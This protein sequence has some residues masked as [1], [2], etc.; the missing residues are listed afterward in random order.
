MTPTNPDNDFTPFLPTTYNI[1]EESDRMPSY[2]VDNLSNFAD[3]INDKVIGAYTEDVASQNGKKFSYDTT[4]KVR[5]GA[6]AIARI[7]SFVPQT[8]PLPIDDVNEQFVI[9]L[10]YG[11]ASLPCSKVGAGDGDYFSFFSEGNVKIQFT[12]S[13]TKLVITT[14]GTTAAYSGF[15]IIEFIRDGT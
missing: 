1:P 11:S 3:V 4:K 7:K 8:I 2:L 14:N 15:I 9:S 6:Q 5:N 13:D 12:M 10:A